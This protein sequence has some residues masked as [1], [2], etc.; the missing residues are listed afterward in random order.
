MGTSKRSRR[1]L[2]VGHWLAHLPDPGT[3]RTE[4]EFFSVVVDGMEHAHFLLQLGVAAAPSDRAATQGLTRRQAVVVGHMVRM[5]KL[6][7]ACRLHFVRE[8]LEL[9]AMLTR[10]IVETD[11]RLMYLMKNASLHSYKSYV[12]ASYKPEKYVL[13]D[14]E[15]KKKARPL[16]S[17]E[18][19]MRASIL[20]D[21]K[22]DGISRTALE[23]NS[24]W[25]MDGKSSR[26]L[27]LSIKRPETYDYG[28]RMGSHWVHGDWFDL[29]RNHLTRVGSRYFPVLEYGKPDI[30][31]AAP[32]AVRC[33]DT[34]LH[35][36][37]WSKC[38]ASELLQ[39]FA[40]RVR[41]AIGAV[42]AEHEMRIVR[43]T[44]SLGEA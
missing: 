16:T 12:M 31:M 40:V 9:V 35:Y 14:L 19:R 37:D 3:L 17:I 10:L 13:Q 25:D 29:K 20:R 42:D 1:L 32:T 43:A 30:R 5:G 24:V 11:S 21:L 33:L 6:F 39:Q 34:L 41:D 2:S 23:Q 26:A 44:Q 27:A 15:R 18:K 38:E 7:D 4:R 8:E 36:L 22:S 28:F